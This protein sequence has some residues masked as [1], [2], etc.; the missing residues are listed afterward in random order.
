MRLSTF[1]EGR[2][3][4][5]MAEWETFARRNAPER[6]DMSDLALRDHARE[7]LAAVARDLA[8]PQSAQE[9]W[10]KSQGDSDVDPGPRTAAAIHGAL[11]QSSDFSLLQL[12]AEFRALR[13]TVLRLWLPGVGA[14]GESVLD[15]MVRFN[16][17][18]DQALAQSIIAFSERADLARDLFLAVLGHDLRSPIANVSMVGELLTRADLPTNRVHELGLRASR[19]ARFMRHMVDDLLSYTRVQMGQ[20][21]PTS[22]TRCDV[23]DVLRAAVADAAATYPQANFEVGFSG[24]THARIDAV[25]MQQ[26]LTNLLVNAAQHGDTDR[27]VTVFAEGSEAAIVLRV[28]NHGT[29]LAEADRELIFRPLVQLEE[30]ARD[31]TR[32]SSLGLGLFIARE[33]AHAHGGT[34][35]VSSS[36]AAGTTFETVFPRHPPADLRPATA[37]RPA[38][39][40][41]TSTR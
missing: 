37:D 11:R 6:A 25:R 3:D 36:A 28:T 32:A 9:Q 13:A 27:P 14:V 19:S 33:I 23:A 10:T 7:I 16:E 39:A 1:I 22:P 29:P 5:I 31:D 4:A 2:M 40:S 30:A 34:I 38:T 12:S 8:R 18:I 17:A 41:A 24:D 35:A 21:I 26:L 15:D 20:G